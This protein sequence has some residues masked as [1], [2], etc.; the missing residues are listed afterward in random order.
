M[1]DHTSPLQ[2]R[3][4]SDAERMDVEGSS[5]TMIPEVAWSSVQHIGSQ[6]GEV[7]RH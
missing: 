5:D 3:R 2:H 4:H 1:S 7:E 6:L